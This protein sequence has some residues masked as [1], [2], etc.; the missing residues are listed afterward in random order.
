M[1]GFCFHNDAFHT[2]RRVLYLRCNFFTLPRIQNGGPV[3][4]LARSITLS[5]CG[6]Y[7][8]SCSIDFL[9]AWRVYA[10][11]TNPSF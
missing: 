10:I 1:Y 3:G 4:K 6:C 5:M 8:S 2:Y 7:D 9:I 11:V